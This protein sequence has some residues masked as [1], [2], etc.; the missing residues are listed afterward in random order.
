M[1]I[2]CGRNG[3]AGNSKEQ[4]KGKGNVSTKCLQIQAIEAVV[5]GF[6]AYAKTVSKQQIS[7]SGTLIERVSLER[8]KDGAKGINLK[9]ENV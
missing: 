6:L 7:F 2:V 8:W 9:S 5:V 4:G 1:Q 3:T